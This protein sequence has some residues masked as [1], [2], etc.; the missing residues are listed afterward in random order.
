MLSLTPRRGTRARPP[1]P[2]DPACSGAG[3]L[4][5]AT[6]LLVPS[7]PERH[8]TRSPTWGRGFFGPRGRPPASRSQGRWFL[9][10]VGFP[11]SV[12]LAELSGPQHSPERGDCL[13]APEP[14]TSGQPVPAQGPSRS[15]S[16][17]RVTA[18]ARHC[19]G[20]RAAAGHC[21]GSQPQPVP[22]QGR[23]RSRALPRSQSRRA[24]WAGLD[25]GMQCVSST[26]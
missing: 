18:A 11:A 16:P 25:Q 22:A 14:E 19:R 15:Q 2:G 1:P 9:S 23:S 12:R 3:P 13:C 17:P 7:S 6:S 10:R 21:P 8:R 4:E 26:Q 5:V 24:G 20:R